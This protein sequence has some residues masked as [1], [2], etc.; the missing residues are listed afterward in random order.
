MRDEL[1]T[2]TTPNP[3]DQQP[4]E[5]TLWYDR[6]EMY[7]F[8]GTR[9]TMMGLYNEYRR[10]RG[11]GPANSP[12]HAWS[13]AYQAW[14]WKDRATAWDLSLIERRKEE[15]DQE[16]QNNKRLRLDMAEALREK[17]LESIQKLDPADARWPEVTAAFRAVMEESRKE[18]NDEPIQRTEQGEPGDFDVLAATLDSKLARL[19]AEAEKDGVSPESI[20]ERESSSPVPMGFLGAERTATT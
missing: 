4:G 13:R 8:Q 17:V 11:R 2:T 18:Y 15:F 12:P 6:F 7:R 19:A 16:R 14:R 9:R 5:P 1:A 10:A 3:W 20:P